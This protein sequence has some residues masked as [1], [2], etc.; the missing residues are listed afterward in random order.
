MGRTKAPSATST[1]ALLVLAVAGGCLLMHGVHGESA[2]QPTAAQ[3]YD[4]PTA[5]PTAA[6]SGAAVVRPGPRPAG[7]G[8]PGPHHAPPNHRIGPQPRSE[9][10][11]LRIPAIGVDA[12][13]T[14]LGLDKKGALAM[15]PAGKADYAG[16][17]AKGPAPGEAGAAIVAGHLDSPTGRAVFYGLGSLR[18]KKTIEIT[19]RDGRTAVFTVD[20]AEVYPKK[21]FPNQKVY[22]ST[23]AP[24]L[25]IITCGGAF[26][27][28]HGYLGNVVVYATLTRVKEPAGHS[29]KPTSR[30]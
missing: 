24:Q 22:R 21:N 13:V 16:W 25:R 14:K 10:V 2:P 26:S 18:K 15:P 9:P 23:A 8:S 4:P 30:P 19:R 27:R 3:A 7:S 20:A 1:R 29:T 6:P 28:S 12:P 11:R 5:A 17:Y